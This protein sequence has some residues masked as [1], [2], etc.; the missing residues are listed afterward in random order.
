MLAIKRR[1]DAILGLLAIVLATL[2]CVGTSG[3]E[4]SVTEG[5]P[6]CT[7]GPF[8]AKQTLLLDIAQPK[9]QSQALP[10]VLMVHGGGWAGGSRADYRY[11]IDAIAAQGMVGVSID[12]R[13]APQNTFP[14]PLQDVKC[15][16]RWI[17]ENAAK[18]QMDTK[19]V[20]AMGGSAG[21][22]LVALLG[23]TAGMPEFE[24]SG[25]YANQSSHIDAMVLH[26]GPYDLGR[27]VRQAQAQPTAQSKLGVQAV[28]MLLGGNNDPESQA[29]RLAS[30][31]TYVSQNTVPTLLI[32]GRKDTLVPF[33]EATQM[34]A[35]IQ[36]KHVPSKILLID[37]A[38][39]GDFGANPGPIVLDLIAFLKGG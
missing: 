15:A 8:G 27:V 22:H 14:A 9:G 20:V 37:D 18:Y 30:P 38:G 23:S 25:G 31:T 24:G 2:G 6:F 26:A 17:R 39:H 5:V 28:H 11:M 4:V 32:H 10:V 3:G 29:Y 34:H 21:A 16:V 12:Y 7:T 33:T 35:L 36:S 1:Y 19:R 13:L